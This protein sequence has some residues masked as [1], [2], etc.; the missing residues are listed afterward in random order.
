MSKAFTLLE[1]LIACA[2]ITIG[3]V[4]ALSLISYSVSSYRFSVQKSTDAY[5]AQACIENARNQRDRNSEDFFGANFYKE[6]TCTENN[7]TVK[8]YLYDWK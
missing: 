7:I 5:K 2:I 6:I 3:L 8:T 1:V 4:G